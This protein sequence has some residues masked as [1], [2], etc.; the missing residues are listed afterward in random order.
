MVLAVGRR[1]VDEWTAL[2]K[3]QLRALVY[4][5]LGTMFLAFLPAGLS[6]MPRNAAWRV[7]HGCFFVFHASVF[8]WYSLE[9]RRNSFPATHVAR[10]VVAIGLGILLMEAAVSLGFI[11]SAAPYLYLLA[12]VWFL[13]LAASV[14]AG[15]VF[16]S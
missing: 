5:S 12:L 4:W 3:F 8:A 11:A 10:V 15:L 1:G 7:A 16:S 6:G 2:E 13:F 14:F 9:A